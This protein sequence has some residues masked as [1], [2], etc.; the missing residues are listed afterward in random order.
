MQKIVVW[1]VTFKQWN[2]I[3]LLTKEDCRRSF[4]KQCTMML[5]DQTTSQVHSLQVSLL[6]KRLYEFESDDLF[7][8]KPIKHTIKHYDLF[9]LHVKFRAMYIANDVVQQI[10]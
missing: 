9:I 6:G 2:E 1:R 4:G 7:G 10:Q 5:L 3:V 8:K